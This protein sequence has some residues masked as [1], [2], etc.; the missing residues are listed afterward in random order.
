[1]AGGRR[2]PDGIGSFTPPGP[3][4]LH[5]SLERAQHMNSGNELPFVRLARHPAGNHPAPHTSNCRQAG[6]GLRV[7]NGKKVEITKAASFSQKGATVADLS[8]SDP[9]TFDGSEMLDR[10]FETWWALWK[11][12]PIALAFRQQAA[13]MRQMLEGSPRPSR[14]IVL[15]PAKK[16]LGVTA[17]S[18]K[19]PSLSAP[20]RPRQDLTQPS[21]PQ[22]DVQLS[23]GTAVGGVR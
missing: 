3:G 7:P 21:D 19:R 20:W 13:R 22:S 17:T 23:Y 18:A 1:M 9:A 15:S 6:S 4:P 14:K 5:I 12:S 2:S 8:A 11:M 16:R 10:Q